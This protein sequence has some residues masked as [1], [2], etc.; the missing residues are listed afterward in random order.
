MYETFRPCYS[1]ILIIGS[2]LS[3]GVTNKPCV[4]QP[5]ERAEATMLLV[6]FHGGKP[7]KNPHKNNVHAY[8][9]DGSKLSS[10]VLGDS[11]AITLDELRGIHF[12]GNL[13]YVVNAN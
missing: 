12:H 3:S 5:E 13:L 7:E 4:S 10:S 1:T 2:R 6:T 8:D 11:E 9:K